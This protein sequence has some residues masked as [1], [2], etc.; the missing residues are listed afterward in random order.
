VKTETDTPRPWK[1]PRLARAAF[2]AGMG[3][4]MAEIAVDL[5]VKSQPRMV[6]HRL[7]E[8]GIAPPDGRRM[9]IVRLPDD[10]APIV[11]AAQAHNLKPLDL[12]SKIIAIVATE[13]GL[14]DRI[15]DN[16]TKTV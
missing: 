11:S 14:I 15:L 8:V 16:E 1:A 10:M 9:A 6:E 12:I 7:K 5:G 13:P 4:S 2:L 3:C